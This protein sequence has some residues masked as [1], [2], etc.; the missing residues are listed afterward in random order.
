MYPKWF[1]MAS[2]LK[3]RWRKFRFLLAYRY[4]LKFYYGERL[5]DYP[6]GVGI[7]LL[8]SRFAFVTQLPLL[9]P[10]RHFPLNYYGA[11]M[12]INVFA[13]PIT[14]DRAF[15]VYEYWMARLFFDLVKDE[16]T[17][18]DIGAHKGSYSLLCAKLMND[19]GRVLA[20]EPDPENCNWI[21][22]NIQANGYKCI[23]LHQCALSDR[24]GSATFYAA[25]GLGSLVSTSLPTA[26]DK[27]PI[28]V[29][30][31]MLDTV[32]NAENIHIVDIIKVDVEGA[33]LL[34]LKGAERTLRSMNVI[35]L[36]DIDI[37]SN[38]E[39]KELFDFLTD[40][41]FQVYRLGREFTPINSAN[42]LFLYDEK[43]RPIG[44]KPHHIVRAIYA[45]KP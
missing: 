35:L 3:K 42:E 26:Y 28:T 29:Q 27:K 12:Y 11:K 7:K 20:F 14:M 22:K 38:A 5:R 33:D 36:M 18:L 4:F 9:L 13:S 31:R 25:N 17:I 45:A 10:D 23:E 41:G 24:E 1:S 40:C 30:T 34:V 8:L 2:A 32:L 37:N 15:G 16:M 19:R 21:K 43:R 44:S 39:R 6:L